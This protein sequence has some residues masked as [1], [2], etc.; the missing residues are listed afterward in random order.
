M[1]VARIAAARVANEPKTVGIVDSET[2]SEF[3]QEDIAVDVDV[4]AGEAVAMVNTPISGV[5]R[6]RVA[7]GSVSTCRT[8]LVQGVS[9]LFLRML[10]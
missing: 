10:C 8:V 2:C 1:A 7:V 9:E 4:E 6:I 3:V 5:W